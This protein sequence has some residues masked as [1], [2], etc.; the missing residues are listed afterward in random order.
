MVPFISCFG[1]R[2][3]RL[4]LRK[5]TLHTTGT[6]IGPVSRRIAAHSSIASR[7]GPPEERHPSFVRVA[8][9][10]PRGAAG[11]FSEALSR[12][13]LTLLIADFLLARK[14]GVQPCPGHLPIPFGCFSGNS[15]DL[16]GFFHTQS[17]KVA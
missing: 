8:D 15:E 10:P 5:Y 17:A 2:L 16:G 12:L 6:G 7:N 4:Y 3:R 13:S 11:V 14:L 9:H 1:R